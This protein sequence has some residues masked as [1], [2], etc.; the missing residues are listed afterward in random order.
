MKPYAWSCFAC[1]HI[2]AADRTRCERCGCPANAT[3]A[4]IETARR[5][6]RQR[7]GLPPEMPADTFGVIG[8]L[9]WMLM[10]AAVLS[11][12]GGLSL[13]VA[14][15]ASMMAFGSLLL[16]LAALCLS[17]YRRPASVA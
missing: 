4:V 7:N 2:N 16:S 3:N 8:Q 15:N 1:E 11:L 5:T 10:G 13:I 6:Y 9:P 17:S 12:L 14:Q